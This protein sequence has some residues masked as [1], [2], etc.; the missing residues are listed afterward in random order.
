MLYFFSF[1]CLIGK[2]TKNELLF[3]LNLLIKSLNKYVIKYKFIIYTN[4]DLKIENS[5]IKIRKYYNHKDNE[6]LYGTD[7]WKNLSMNKLFIYKDLYEEFKIN[8]IWI[9]LD[10]YIY[11]NLQ[12]LD[13]LDNFFIEYGGECSTMVDIS[14]NFKLKYKNV[15]QGNFWKLNIDLYKKLII[16]LNDLKKNKIIL[17]YDSQSLFSYY[18]Y[19]YLN[20]NLKN[21]NINIIGNNIHPN[22][23]NGIAVWCDKN[24][25]SHATIDGLNNMFINENRLKSKYHINKEIH[26][27]SFTFFTL[28]KIKNENKFKTLF[29]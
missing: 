6:L 12:Y 3:A 5:N 11:H 25:T 15:I 20:S 9:D 13:N 14:N 29:T 10:T 7:K 2:Q 17:K 18:F 27:V 4:F 1:C 8:Y 19:K 23:L 21:D 24:K 28:M 26:I 22:I 16:L